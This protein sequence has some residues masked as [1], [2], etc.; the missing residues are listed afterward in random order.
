MKADKKYPAE[1]YADQVCSGAIPVC[2]Y[3]RLAVERYY[4]DLDR[5]LDKD[6]ISIRKPLCAL[7]TSSRNSNTPKVSGR[8]N[9]FGW[10]RGNSSPCGISSDGKCRRYASLS[11]RLYRDRS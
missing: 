7:S 6:G 4:A 1:L 5:S 9:A 8:G 3:V 11:I 10:S 2:E